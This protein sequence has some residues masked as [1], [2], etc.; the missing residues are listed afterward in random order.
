[1][2][3]DRLEIPEEGDQRSGRDRAH[4]TL[5]G[6]PPAIKRSQDHRR[7]RSGINGVRI[8]RL[9]QHRVGIQCLVECPDS[10]QD[11]N[12]PRDDKNAL[13]RSPGARCSGLK[14]SLTRLVEGENR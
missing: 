6:R 12:Q 13:V 9:S 2:P 1:M 11:Q 14:T 3:L 10:E 7:E 4:R 5:R 8:K